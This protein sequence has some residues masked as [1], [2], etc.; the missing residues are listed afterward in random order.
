MGKMKPNEKED[1]G[2]GKQEILRETEVKGLLPVRIRG[3][4]RSAQEATEPIKT[5]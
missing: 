5:G 1:T 3:D 4:T 2:P